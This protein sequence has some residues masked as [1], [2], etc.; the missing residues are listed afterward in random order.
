MKIVASSQPLLDALS[1]ASLALPSR[2]SMPQLTSALIEA[3]GKTVRISCDSLQSRVTV[4]RE[5]DSVDEPFSTLCPPRLL[6]A[7]LRGNE[8]T[9]I[10]TERD[11]K[12]KLKIRS[13]GETT[14]QTLYT[15]EFPKA[16]PEVET[17]SVDAVKLLTALKIGIACADPSPSTQSH[18]IYYKPECHHLYASYGNAM[19]VYPIDLGS[20]G[21]ILPSAQAK[22]VLSLFDADDMEF[23]MKGSDLHF[24]QGQTKVWLKTVEGTPFNHLQMLPKAEPFASIPRKELLAK[25]DGLLPFSDSEAYCKVLIEPY[26]KEWVISTR[27]LGSESSAVLEDVE[28]MDGDDLGPF[29]ISLQS[30]VRITKNWSCERMKIRRNQ[31]IV[32][33]DAEDD[34]GCFSVAALIRP[35]LATA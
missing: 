25:L 26:G 10:Y 28:K 22:I 24:V 15:S 8:A 6:K 7:A 18:C 3:E 4:E 9:L 32:Q 21:F 1:I 19:G 2:V 33:L 13:G 16:W 29:T 12:P 11:E 17:S 14:L 34:S 30:L 23:G 35:E 27:N 5:V 20:Q 31:N